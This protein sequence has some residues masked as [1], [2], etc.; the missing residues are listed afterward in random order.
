MTINERQPNRHNHTKK[1]KDLLI[2]RI[3]QAG[4][5]SFTDDSWYYSK[6]HKDS[7]P[8][9]SY[10]I[11][12]YQV[13]SQYRDWVKY[14]ALLCDSSTSHIA[15]K[16][17]CIASFLK[18]IDSFY[19]ELSLDK[20]SRNHVNAFEYELKLSKGSTNKKQGTYAAIQDFFMKLSDFDEMPNILPTKDINPFRQE[21]KK[22][23]E[24]L[25]PKKVLYKWDRAM[26]DE[27]LNIS[28]E[29]RTLYWLIR[30]FPNRITEILSMKRDCLKS[31]YSE[32]VI[33]IPTFKQNG[34]Y[35]RAE[36]KTIPVIYNGHGKYVIDLVK[37]LQ[38]QTEQFL[39]SFSVPPDVNKDY[40]FVV[41][42]WGFANDNGG[43]GI[44]FDPRYKH[45]V[46][47]WKGVK[48]N[49]LLEQLA[50]I[51][52]IHDDNGEVIIPTT[53]QFRHNAVTD[54]LYTVGYTTEQVRRLTGH[55]NEAM[56]KSYTHQLVEQHKAIHLSIS[57]LRNPK[58]SP[59][60]FRGKIL[61]LD[62]RTTKQL[63]KDSRRY[64][65]WEVNGKKGVGICSD[66][67]GCNPKGTSVHFECYAC[68]WFVPKLEYYDDYK[69]E[70]AYWREMVGRTAEDPS[71][72]A[73]FE[74]AVRNMSYLERILTICKNG[75]EEFKVN[76]LE[77][78]LNNHTK[79]HEW[80]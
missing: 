7:L 64:L 12:F 34:G 22:Q 5:F 60:E 78:K 58:D 42:Y 26:K 46:T 23:N 56:T 47:N 67:S 19:P 21:H 14:Y 75:I 48:V 38:L 68:D 28:L 29:F 27:K 13:P 43:I 1:L 3:S 32:Y 36:P 73:H 17:L 37:K 50:L 15:K 52:D 35:E 20:I 40:L 62:D 2:G 39:A 53:H 4:D 44:R 59:V 41:R 69:L 33:R 71:R 80:E 25:L 6:K 76:N 11:T 16:C 24:K 63:S 9:G 18:F 51:L 31:F 55:K 66:I 79:S 10:T 8:K 74:N 45:R 61:N 49:K 77:E 70:Y 57:G 65:T 54:R 30:S 72:S